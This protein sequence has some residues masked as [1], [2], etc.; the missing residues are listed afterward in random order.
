[1]EILRNARN[2]IY[3]SMRFLDVSL[4]SLYFA[5]DLA[6]RGIATD[7]S[8]LFF[9][10][11]KLAAMY[12][13][14]R[15]YVNRVYLHA[16]LHCLFCHIWNRKKRAEDYWNLACD[17]AVESIIDSLYR[18]CV[19][20]PLSS[21]RR[22]LYGRLEKKITVFNAESVYKALQE[23]NLTEEEY[24]RF[25][26]EFWRDDHCKWG[27]DEKPPQP[28]QV[29]NR[30]E[31]W[32][33]K[34][35]K[36]QVEME[37]F[38]NEASDDD[39][40]LMNQLAVENRERYNYKEFLRKFSVLK[41]TVQVDPDAFDYVFY[42]YGMELYGNMPLIEPME[43]KEIRRIEDFVIVID[44]SMSCS[45]DLVKKFLEETYSVLSHSE[46]FFKKVNIHIIQ[47]DDQ[48][49]E[50]VLIQNHD[51]LRYYMD[52]LELH[53]MGGTDFRPAFIHVD[54]M[55]KAQKFRSLK[56]LIYFTDG[57]GIFP[58]KMPVYDVAFVFMQ[59]NYNDV[60]VPPWA[61]KIILSPEDI[62]EEVKVAKW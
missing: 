6:V 40:D 42:H 24:Q 35:E 54:K 38:A 17:I 12:K 62:G 28:N 9:N 57:Y 47:C 2:E 32:D 20:L 46:S 55:V 49:R 23:L 51:D 3:L 36:M 31:D 56:G 59:E 33:D 19:H 11:S 15:I 14:S 26:A 45:G 39:K 43:T 8:G 50:D 29:R 10:P 18:S 27:K 13:K 4:S 61:I 22:D 48:V 53:G 7:G 25:S 30:K 34:R 5:P 21:A 44:T 58:V 41:E 1:M 52:N 37:A 16:V 60:D